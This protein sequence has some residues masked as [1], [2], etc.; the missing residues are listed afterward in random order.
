MESEA[1]MFVAEGRI[2]WS[3]SDVSAAAE[4]E[5]ALLRQLD[6]RLGRAT[7]IDAREDPLLEHIAR[8]G[9]RHEAEVLAQMERHSPVIRLSHAS[10]PLTHE[11]RT[12]AAATTLEVLRDAG[13]AGD[14]VVYQAAFYDG[15]F[16]GYADF[17]ERTPDGWR[18]CDAKLAREAKPHAL[19]Q[20]GGYAAQLEGLGLRVAPT[21]SLLLGDGRRENFRTSDVVPVFREREAALRTLLTTHLDGGTPLAWGDDGGAV[22]CGRCAE[23]EHAATLANDLVLVAGMRMD[24]RRKLRAAGIVTLEDLAGAARRPDGMARA[25]F[26]KLRAQA[27]LQWRQLSG[28]EGAPVEYELVEAAP[29]TLALL[30]APSAGDL[31]FDFE[32][33]PIYHESDP[34]RIGLEY[35]WGMMDPAGTYRAL[36]AHSRAGERLAFRQFMGLVAERRAA[37]PDMH[38]YHYA[39]YEVSAL[40]RIAMRYQLLEKELDDL[41]RSEVFVDLYATVRGSVRVSAPSYSIKKLEPLYMGEHLRSDGEGA[42]AEGADSVVAYHEFR[43]M[44]GR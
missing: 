30:P 25:V 5:Y 32:G 37:Y 34:T 44:R 10:P 39:A 29:A 41:L 19:L 12:E 35:L 17:L 36:W 16:F 33:D 11:S 13:G 31:F 4:C 24:Q 15:E 22:A 9:D 23:C 42:V 1:R 27:Q 8:L 18:V 2:G 43:E 38:I 40:K 7:P 3:A 26:E 21:V 28:G 20:L 6:Y 14:V